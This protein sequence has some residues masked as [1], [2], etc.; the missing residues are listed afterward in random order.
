M[1]SFHKW[2]QDVVSEFIFRV[3]L[4]LPGFEYAL[5]DGAMV[6][7]HQKATGRMVINQFNAIWIRLAL[8]HLIP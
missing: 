2:V 8:N 3:I 5:I 6:K 1:R 4:G 7:I